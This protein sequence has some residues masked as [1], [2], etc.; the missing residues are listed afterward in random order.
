MRPPASLDEDLAT[1]ANA[2]ELT[3]HLPVNLTGQWGVYEPGKSKAIKLAPH[4]SG[5]AAAVIEALPKL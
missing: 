1:A 5:L 4:I 2:G 3:A